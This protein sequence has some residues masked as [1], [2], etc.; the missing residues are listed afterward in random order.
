MR[1]C[2]RNRPPWAWLA[3][4]VSVVAALA[5]A[6]VEAAPVQ[7][8]GSQRILIRSKRI[9]LMGVSVL[10]QGIQATLAPVPL[11]W[12]YVPGS[13]VSV[14]YITLLLRGVPTDKGTT[15]L[16]ARS[17]KLVPDSSDGYSI[18]LPILKKDS[19]MIFSVIDA[20]GSLEE[21]EVR[22]QITLSESAI[23]VD[24]SCKE[25][26]LKIRELKRP[27]GPNLMFVG[28]KLGTRPQELSLDVLWSDV[29]RIEYSGKVIEAENSVIT[30]PLESR[31][32][33]EAAIIGLH[34]RSLRSIYQLRYEPY[35]PP[36]YEFW[37]GL[38][39]F[40]ASFTQSNFGSK[41]SGMS[42]A[43]LGQFWYRPEDVRLSI[44]IRGFGTIAQLSHSLDPPAGEDSVKMYFVDAEARFR[45]LDRGGW[46]LD[47]FLGA[48]VV[49]MKVDTRR[50]GVQ[51]IIDPIFGAV[52]QRSVGRRDWLGLTLRFVPLQSF[53]N[54]LEF[55]TSQ[56]YFEGEL[57]YVHPLQLRNRL[58]VTAYIGQLK[59]APGAP[60]ADTEGSF[61][62]IGA[63]Y[64]W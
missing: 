24:E 29:E 31:R 25:F 22:V 57:T 23:F 54:P 21:W 42:A 19:Q 12:D 63:G 4:A 1:T 3:A 41:F 36:P 6:A 46:R 9:R 61:L 50:F 55:S 2:A 26:H 53:F 40:S 16:A 58:F 35:V 51:R 15:V 39:M 32:T 20:K 49:F 7:S 38:G 44:M 11:Q 33:S 34:D 64:G 43:F 18:R 48:W 52:I 28:C 59:Y 10:K 60:L 13:S 47:P 45:V 30:V 5:S 27:A 62:L 17:G 56:A 8:M 14:P 37:A